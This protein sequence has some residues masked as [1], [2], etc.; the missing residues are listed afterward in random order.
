MPQSGRRRRAEKAL[1]LACFRGRRR[2]AARGGERVGGDYGTLRTDYSAPTF[3]RGRR[4]HQDS[5]RRLALVDISVSALEGAALGDRHAAS[6]TR[7]SREPGF[8]ET[9]PRHA[10]HAVRPS[11]YA[12]DVP[13][14]S[15]ARFRRDGRAPHRELV[16]ILSHYVPTRAQQL[17]LRRAHRPSTPSTRRRG[18]VVFN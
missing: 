8:S 6:R 3:G 14:Y 10:G 15:L 5:M 1:M 7:T 11:Q 17:L 16:L 12:V 4:H 18:P 13:Q 2:G 9:P